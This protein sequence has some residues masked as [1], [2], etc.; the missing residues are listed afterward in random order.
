MG[1]APTEQDLYARRSELE[2]REA[3]L[4]RDIFHARMTGEG[5]RELRAQ[6]ADVVLE[7]AAIESELLDRQERKKAGRR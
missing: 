4:N 7:L 2:G 1:R 6:Q 5:M 3:D